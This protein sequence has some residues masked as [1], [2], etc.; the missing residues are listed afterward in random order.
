MVGLSAFLRLRRVVLPLWMPHYAC[1]MH[2]LCMPG[3]QLTRRSKFVRISKKIHHFCQSHE[4][5][6]T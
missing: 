6:R 1:L 5:H 3:M 2:A 4:C